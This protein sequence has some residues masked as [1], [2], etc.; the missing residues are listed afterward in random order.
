MLDIVT[1]RHGKKVFYEEQKKNEIYVAT[2]VIRELRYVE[3]RR[4][5][6]IHAIVLCV[7]DHAVFVIINNA[8]A[9]ASPPRQGD[10]HDRPYDMCTDESSREEFIAPQRDKDYVK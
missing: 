4:G 5:S 9:F 1:Q 8:S 3:C 6:M 10:S 7:W 2:M